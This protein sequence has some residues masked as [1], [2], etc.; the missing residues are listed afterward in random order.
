MLEFILIVLT[1]TIIGAF[2]FAAYELGR[3]R[4]IAETDEKYKEKEKHEAIEVN[5]ANQKYIKKFDDFIKFNG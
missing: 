5:K 3:S 1:S 4:G 2:Y